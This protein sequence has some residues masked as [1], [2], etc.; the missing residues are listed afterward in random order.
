MCV[1]NDQKRSLQLV[2]IDHEI[3]LDEA[4]LWSAASA[5]DLAALAVTNNSV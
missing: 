2:K 3:Q 4:H 1:F 5:K